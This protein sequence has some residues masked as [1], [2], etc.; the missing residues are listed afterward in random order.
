MLQS[1]RVQLEDPAIVSD[2]E[3]LIAAHAEME[4]AQEKVDKLYARWAELE[5]KK[6]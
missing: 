4:E 3:R 1:K 2:S 5:K 6:N